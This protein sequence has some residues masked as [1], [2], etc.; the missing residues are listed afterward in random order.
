MT[1]AEAVVREGLV[2]PAVAGVVE[3][4]GEVVE[5]C[6]S[7]LSLLAT[8]LGYLLRLAGDARGAGASQQAFHWVHNSYWPEVGYQVT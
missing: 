7:L 6:S 1:G 5:V 4:E 3:G 2:R 8:R